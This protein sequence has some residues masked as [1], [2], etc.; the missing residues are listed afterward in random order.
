[1]FGNGGDADTAAAA[2][3]AMAEAAR[4]ANAA[5]ARMVLAAADAYHLTAAEDLQRLPERDHGWVGAGARSDVANTLG[6]SGAAAQQMI[7]IGEMLCDTLPHTKKWFEAGL[8]EYGKVKILAR[9]LADVTPELIPRIEE[10]AV[11]AARFKG[12]QG[13]RREIERLITN[14]GPEEAARL[15]R[16]AGY[17]RKA[18]ITP[19]YHG[20]ARFY[21]R[22]TAT[23]AG[24]A[25]RRLQEVASTV[26][27]DD[28]R[29]GP[30]LMVDALMALLNGDTQLQ[31]RCGRDTCPMKHYV[32]PEHSAVVAHVHVDPETLLGLV[33]DPAMLSGHGDIDPELARQLAGDATWKVIIDRARTAQRAGSSEMR[34]IE[35]PAGCVADPL[36]ERER[37]DPLPEPATTVDG[38][39]R[40]IAEIQAMIDAD[41]GVLDRFDGHGG[42]VSPPKGA[43]TYRPSRALR[44]AVMAKYPTCVHPNCTVPSSKCQIDHGIPFD[45]TDPL[46]GGWT[47]LENLQPRCLFHHQLHTLRHHR[48][49]IL[50]SGAVV[51]ISRTG[52][53][54]V[55][56]PDTRYGTREN[57]EP[58]PR[59]RP[60]WEKVDDCELPPDDPLYEATWWERSYAA[61]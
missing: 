16:E 12:P 14:A 36:P 17:G 3:T 24:V 35:L 25:R 4:Q 56:L 52:V 45:H 6:T 51:T 13:L 28:Y 58:D 22:L 48:I 44:R 21:A 40:I 5:H 31:C 26:C 47:I 42:Y 29:R 55:S 8:L 53:V 23:E 15:R 37:D 2:L 33:D 46:A 50:D 39:G 11:Q 32:A 61:G 27:P 30:G 49:V 19:D 54:G 20:M 57:P 10:E 7:D 43:L 9:M 38:H 1:M 60:G 59:P 18:V 41:P 34:P